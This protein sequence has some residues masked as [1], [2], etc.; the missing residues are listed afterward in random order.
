MLTGD[1]CTRGNPIDNRTELWYNAIV[2][3]VSRLHQYSL[4]ITK[5][6]ADLVSTRCFYDANLQFAHSPRFVW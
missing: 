1:I 4:E 2:H 6:F 5:D 3:A